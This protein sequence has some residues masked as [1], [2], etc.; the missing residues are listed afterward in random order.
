MSGVKIVLR[1]SLHGKGK[2]GEKKTKGSFHVQVLQVASRYNEQERSTKPVRKSEGTRAMISAKCSKEQQARTRFMKAK[3][4]KSTVVSWQSVHHWIGSQKHKTCTSSRQQS[5][6][7]IMMIKL[8]R[9]SCKQREHSS[10]WHPLLK[11]LSQSLPE[12]QEQLSFS[13]SWTSWLPKRTTKSWMQR[14]KW[15]STFRF[16]LHVVV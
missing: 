1:G 3:L 8:C 12:P 9:S 4:W 2:K 10:D 14:S 16:Y 13:D 7:L 15:F 11:S 6:P 5:L